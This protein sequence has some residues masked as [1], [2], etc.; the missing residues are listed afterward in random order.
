MQF[1]KC[2]VFFR[3]GSL[4]F[5]FE[6]VPRGTWF[7]GA[8]DGEANMS[9]ARS[10]L[11]R[12]LSSLISVAEEEALDTRGKS[13]T[14]VGHTSPAASSLPGG[15]PVMREVHEPPKVDS[16]EIRHAGPPA[17][18]VPPDGQLPDSDMLMFVPISAVAPNP[19]Q[20]RKRFDESRLAELAASLRLSGVIQPIIVRPSPTA[21][22]QYQLIAGERRWRAAMIAG[23][24][25]IPAI[26]RQV[27]LATQARLALIE[28]VQREDLN[29]IERAT[30]YATLLKTLGLTQQELA[31]QLGE[32]RSSIANFLRLLELAEPVQRLVADGQLSAGHAK[33]L[34][35]VSDIA[36]Q[37][38]LAELIVKDGLSVRG[39]EDV[40]KKG[41]SPT[42]PA[43]PTVT[44]AHLLDLEKSLARQ[45]GM[46]VQI[47][48]MGKN[49]SKGQLVIHYASLDQFDQLLERMNVRV[50][51]T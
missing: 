48:A 7:D 47:R 32:D 3:N 39:L 14:T 20:P 28:N 27:D 26:V 16:S 19:H 15:L 51:E 35:G 40:I 23:L 46:R 29:P 12:G 4:R 33:V 31:Q 36:D 38:R 17:A 24:D 49:K 37:C 9:K 2:V 34:A 5:D 8:I 50:E 44:S 10:R 22:G 11:G 25:T 6:D 42:A 21:D 1:T 30:A 41:I 43:T 45:I 13:A 18:A